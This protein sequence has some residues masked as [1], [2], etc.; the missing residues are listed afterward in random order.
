MKKIM[1]KQVICNNKG[2]QKQSVGIRRT[3]AETR[4]QDEKKKKK[5]KLEE[6]RGVRMLQ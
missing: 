1:V 3:K 4:W 5:N 2:K 6:E